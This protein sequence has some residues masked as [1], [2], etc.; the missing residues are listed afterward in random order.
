MPFKSP[1][2]KAK[3]NK[4]YYAINKKALNL[5]SRIYGATHKKEISANKK[6]Y[7]K[8]YQDELK[9]KNR[10]HYE[11]RR[12][13][14]LEKQKAYA[15]KTKEPK[16]EYDKKY[17][18]ANKDKRSFWNN[19][20]RV[21]KAAAGGSHTLGQWENLKA[22]YNWICP[23]CKKIEP[24]IKL[25]RDPIIPIVKGGSDNIENIQPLCR[26]CNSQKYTEIKKYDY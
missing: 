16:R 15:Q 17:R 7:W 26:N 1:G 6:E 13:E 14:R 24:A 3:Y 19:R 20:R 8:K 2:E 4:Q 5:N 22:Q 25:T 21:S 23:A 18:Q 10:Y 9:V 11:K 12:L